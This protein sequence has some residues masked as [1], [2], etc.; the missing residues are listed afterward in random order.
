MKGPVKRHLSEYALLLVSS[1]FI[2]IPAHQ[3][4]SGGLMQDG[5]KDISD[6]CHIYLICRKP[7]L[8]YDPKYFFFDKNSGSVAGRIAYRKNG[9]EN[10]VPFLG[11]IELVD[12]AV[13][14]K[15]D[16]YPHR[17]FKTIDCN[18]NS[19]R[20]FPALLV[21]MEN[22]LHLNNRDLSC[23][24]VMYIGQAFGQ[25]DRSAL[26]RLKSHSTFQKILADAQYGYP[27]DEVILLGFEYEEIRVIMHLDGINPAKHREDGG[28]F[29]NIRNNP[30]TEQQ[31]VSLVE[32][33]LIRYFQPEYNKIYKNNFPDNTYKILEAC[34][35]L[36]FSGLVVEID[37]TELSLT[38]GSGVVEESDHH[39]CKY[40][41]VSHENR[42]SF[43][44]S[45]PGK[46][47][48]KSFPVW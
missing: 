32:A 11:R 27:D 28:R 39:V 20:S 33:G 36:D 45:G 7:S 44:L 4:N 35:K 41:L 34:Y 1:R 29:F 30:P 6:K 9:I 18:G 31:V 24:D 14:V 12:G 16:G 37:T 48:W 3:I 15:L 5:A 40:D 25:G 2:L 17:E 10:S 46:G 22:K 19:T 26:D 47:G 13:D 21:V 42:W 8:Y 38:L 43:F 23:L